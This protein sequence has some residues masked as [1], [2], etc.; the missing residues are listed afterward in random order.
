VVIKGAVRV[1]AI[2]DIDYTVQV[3]GDRT[4]IFPLASSAVMLPGDPLNISYVYEVPSDSTYRT[5]SRSFSVGADWPWSGFSY[6]HDETT[7]TPLN[8]SEDSSLLLDQRRDAAAIWVG[9][10]WDRFRGR[11]TVGVVDYNSTRLIYFETRADEYLIYQPYS[12]LQFNLAASQFRTEYELPTHT[13]TGSSLRLDITWTWWGSWVTSAYAG[14]RSFTDTAQ[15]S[16]RVDEAGF[17]LRRT[18]A[19]LDMNAFAGMQR[20]SRGGVRSVNDFLHF[21]VIRRF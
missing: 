13:T 21:G 14:T 3:I 8:G 11:V 16:E 2:I 20:R 12:N 1:T 4:R 7:Q 17:R 10:I 6:S 9:G 19:L 15:P 18:W 5:S